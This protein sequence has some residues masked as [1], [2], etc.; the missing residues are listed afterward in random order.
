MDYS[1]RNQG[2]QQA[3]LQNVV[4]RLR[5]ARDQSEREQIFM[6][7]KKTPHLFSAFLRMTGGDNANSQMQQLPQDQQAMVNRNM[8]SGPGMS[9]QGGQWNSQQPSGQNQ[10]FYQSQPGQAQM[11]R[12]PGGQFI[13]NNQ[14]IW[15]QQQ[16]QQFHQRQGGSPAMNQFN[17]VRSPPVSGIGRSPSIG[18]MSNAGNPMMQ[19]PPQQPNPQD[20]QQGGPGFR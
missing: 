5:S 7:L 3:L 2:N 16:Q 14:A 17:Q 10:Q 8:R 6:D 11:N 4:Q 13:S 1:G 18:M 20:Q 19:P 15:N 9:G 12:G